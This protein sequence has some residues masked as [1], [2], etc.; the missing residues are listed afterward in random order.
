MNF[1]EEILI[2]QPAGW[3][4]GVS[5]GYM[6]VGVCARSGGEKLNYEKV[7]CAMINCTIVFRYGWLTKL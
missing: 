2:F 7:P 5:E 6:C 3:Q 4:C 1:F